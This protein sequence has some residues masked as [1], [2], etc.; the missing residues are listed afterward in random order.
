MAITA[1]DASENTPLGLATVNQDCEYCGSDVAL[2]A[3]ADHGL[4]IHVTMEWTNATANSD[5]Y[6]I[7]DEMKEAI[8]DAAHKYGAALQFR[9][10]NDANDGQNALG[11]YG[12]ANLRR[13]RNIASVYDP[14]ETFQRLQNGG[15]LL[16][17][18]L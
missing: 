7:M 9:F 8:E 12:T 18:A 10:M 5:I 2:L 15:W 14:S 11:S 1:L 13:L 6:R 16:Q 3:E 17:N 4:G